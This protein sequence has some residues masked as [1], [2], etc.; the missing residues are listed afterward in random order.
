[1]RIMIALIV[2]LCALASPPAQAGQVDRAAENRRA[3]LAPV[4]RVAILPPFFAPDATP[5]PEGK[6]QTVDITAR[7]LYMEQL[8]RLEVRMRARLPER[9]AARTPFE[10]IPHA[11]VEAALED[12]LLTPEQFFQNGGRMRGNRFARPVPE[13]VRRLCAV[14]KA[15]ALLLGT[16]DE[17]RRNN[18]R[19]V[20][21]ACGIWHESPHVRCRA[22]FFV[23]LA[24]GTEVLQQ[25][26]D[27]LRPL[28]RI[29]NREYVFVDWTEAHDQIV[30]SLMDEWTR[31]TPASRQPARVAGGAEQT[32]T[33]D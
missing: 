27:V 25:V 1:M 32:K 5:K 14:L 12:L 33:G 23:L 17:P 4:R 26:V 3:L 21:D 6:G 16:L 8:R 30:E 18:G 28:T 19:T 9:V 20:V 11:Q 31:Y 22:G 7:A 29:G 13:I 24:D 10:V 2:L 15:D